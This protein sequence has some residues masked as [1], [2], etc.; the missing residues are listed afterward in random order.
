LFVDFSTSFLNYRDQVDDMPVG[1][2]QNEFTLSLDD[3]AAYS[4]DTVVADVDFSEFLS[5]VSN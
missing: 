5:I 2:L 1:E 4:P 3:D